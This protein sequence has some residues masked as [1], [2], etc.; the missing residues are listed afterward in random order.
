MVI[1]TD[2]LS[3]IRAIRSGNS[4]S[5]PDLLIQNNQLVDS[6]IRANIII[7]MDWCPS[8]CNVTGNDLA[9]EAAKAG[10]SFGREL[11]LRL[12]KT[13]AYGIIKK[14]VRQK[15]ATIWKNHGKGLRWELDSELPVKM[16]QYSDDRRMD[17]LYTRLRLDRN[18]LNCNNLFHRGLIR[19]VSTAGNWKTQ[20]ITYF[21]ASFTL[22]IDRSCLRKSQTL[23][24]ISKTSQLILF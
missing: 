20:S 11:S 18:G 22:I 3:S 5:R 24:Q 8:H 23:F 12:G 7:Y 6:I 17:R 14:K 19:S 2:S 4:N 16:V 15:W 10:S 9:D 1:L 21:R 13:E